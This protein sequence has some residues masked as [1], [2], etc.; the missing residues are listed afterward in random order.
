MFRKYCVGRESSLS[1]AANLVSSAQNSVSSHFHTKKKAHCTSRV[2]AF[3][4]A[5]SSQL[6]GLQH[7]P[8]RPASTTAQFCKKDEH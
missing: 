3:D 4:G 8:A 2:S 6:R 5:V 1:S 7:Q